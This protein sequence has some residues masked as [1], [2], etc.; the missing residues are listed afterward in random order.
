ML[1]M[2]NLSEHDRQLVEEAKAI[3]NPVDWC[4]VPD[5]NEAESQEVKEFLHRRSSYLY[6]CEEGELI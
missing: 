3:T 2:D 4:L 5:E 6:H 1:N